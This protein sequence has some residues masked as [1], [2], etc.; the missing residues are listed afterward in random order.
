MRFHDLNGVS[1]DIPL[2]IFKLQDIRG[3]KEERRLQRELM[4][5]RNKIAMIEA[6]IIANAII[7]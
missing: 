7:A 3:L 4:S 6:D 2:S 1:V 5:V